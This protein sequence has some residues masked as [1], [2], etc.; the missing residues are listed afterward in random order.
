MAKTTCPK[1][2]GF[3]VIGKILFEKQN[4]KLTLWRCKRK[5]LS[6]L[7]ATAYLISQATEVMYTQSTTFFRKL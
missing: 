1:Y 7:F 4:G 2:N 5:G 6:H 3:R